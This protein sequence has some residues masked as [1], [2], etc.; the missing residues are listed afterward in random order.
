MKKHFGYYSHFVPGPE[1]AGLSRVYCTC[2]VLQ[3]KAPVS[4]KFNLGVLEANPVGLGGPRGQKAGFAGPLL[5]LFVR[6]AAPSRGRSLQN[7]R[8]RRLD[9]GDQRGDPG[10]GQLRPGFPES[11]RLAQVEVGLR[12]HAAASK[13]HVF[14]LGGSQDVA[15]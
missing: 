4:V 1:V 12:E 5:G 13:A 2:N 6:A 15:G 3:R 9:S 11:G 7:L 8:I 14:G 10:V